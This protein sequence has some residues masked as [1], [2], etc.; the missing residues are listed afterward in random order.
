MA[1]LAAGVGG[2][3]PLRSRTAAHEA[4]GEGGTV[5]T[6]GSHARRG[7]DRASGEVRGVGRRAQAGGQPDHHPEVLRVGSRDPGP[8]C[9][10]RGL[11]RNVGRLS[12]SLQP[13]WA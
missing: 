11:Q 13:A 7:W 2:P 10:R 3:S 9:F 8:D 6:V 4:G 1:E 5:G 12:L